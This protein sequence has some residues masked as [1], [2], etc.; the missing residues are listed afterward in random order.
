M[1]HK[2]RFSEKCIDRLKEYCG[3]I[4][5]AGKSVLE[6]TVR[7]KKKEESKPVEAPAVVHEVPEFIIPVIDGITALTDK[8]CVRPSNQDAVI[9]AKNLAGVADGMGGHRGGEVASSAARD[10][11]MGFLD[12]KTPDETELKTA[13]ES[14]NQRLFI[15]QAEDESL[16]GMGTTLTVLWAAETQLY[17]AHVGDSRAYRLREG[18][19]T[20]I[21][22]DHSMVEEMVRQGMLTPEQAACHPMRNVITRAVGTEAGIDVDVI[23]E[24][25]HAGDVWLLCSD[26]LHGMVSDARME[27][28][29]SEN[30]PEEAADILMEAAKEAGGRDNI[31]VVIYLDGEAGQ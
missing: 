8:G 22:H 7:K 27:E 6:T 4:D 26:G 9:V 24:E 3:K 10:L 20:Q 23:V 11:L 5:K 28:V 19:L 29:L 13:V 2:F 12:G 30:K 25:R 18:K 21:T 16:S 15:Q 17:I 1:S 14:V 31:S